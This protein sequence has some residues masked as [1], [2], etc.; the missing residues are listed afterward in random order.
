MKQ[1]TPTLSPV[2]F[3]G[4]TFTVDEIDLMRQ[5]AADC[6]ALGTTE[7]AR[8][9]CELLDWKR[10]TGHL[11]NHECRQ[12]LERLAEKGWLR[13]PPLRKVGP[14][15]ALLWGAGARGCLAV[16][17]ETDHQVIALELLQEG[18]DHLLEL[19]SRLDVAGG[20]RRDDVPEGRGVLELV[21]DLRPARLQAVVGPGSE[22]DHDDFAVD[23]LVNDIRGVHPISDERQQTSLEAPCA[24]DAAML[25]DRRADCQGVAGEGRRHSGDG[26]TG[27]PSSVHATLPT[28]ASRALRR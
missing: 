14:R 16:S 12:L 18:T 22:V 21:P 25:Q 24:K 17:D 23:R 15:G 19:R 13:L 1:T 9:I 26:R 4:R 5:I 20:E 10:P 2:S 3:C 6:S 8:T 7:I 28:R 27:P 11:K